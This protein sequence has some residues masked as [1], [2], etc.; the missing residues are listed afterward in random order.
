M[1]IDA[2]VGSALGFTSSPAS[3]GV[4]AAL[5][6]ANPFMAG[7]Q[8]LTSLFGGND[9]K[10]SK[11]GAGG[12]ADSGSANFFG[13]NVI[14]TKKP[15]PNLQNPLHVALLAGGVVGIIYIYKKHF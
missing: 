13:D 3:A 4:G 1:T 2:A 8:A 5:G 14:S 12:F 6:V 10:I 9:V 15:F 11:T 7:F